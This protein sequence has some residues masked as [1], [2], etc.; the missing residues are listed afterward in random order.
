MFL[1]HWIALKCSDSEMLTANIR[2]KLYLISKSGKSEG[3]QWPHPLYLRLSALISELISSLTKEFSEL[4]IFFVCVFFNVVLNYQINV[5]YKPLKSL[6]WKRNTIN[7]RFF[8]LIFIRWPQRSLLNFLWFCEVQ[9][10][11]SVLFLLITICLIFREYFP[12]SL[13]IPVGVVKIRHKN[14]KHLWYI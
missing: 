3:Q 12:I 10:Y 9:C 7:C 4:R 13:K 2:A 5:Y 8:F 1:K 14:L 11:G 6:S